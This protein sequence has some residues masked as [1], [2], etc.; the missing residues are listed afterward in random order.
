MPNGDCPVGAAH[1]AELTEL[2]RRMDSVEQV[3]RDTCH[4]LE[5]QRVRHARLDG[6]SAILIA[7]IAG[8]ASIVGP[9]ITAAIAARGGQ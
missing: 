1:T 6:W 3:Q 7:L 2:R 5:E 4:E 8:A 9:Y